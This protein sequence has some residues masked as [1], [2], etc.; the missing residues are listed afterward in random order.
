M[1]TS[2]QLDAIG[3][4]LDTGAADS[5]VRLLRSCWE[6]ELPPSELVRMYC[7]WIRGLCETGELDHAAT[8]AKRA[9]AEFPRSPDVLTA[10]GNVLDLTGDYPGAR[11]AFEAAL[12][13]EAASPLLHYN[14]G[15]ILERLGDDDAAERSY[16]DASAIEGDHGPMVEATSAL[17]ALLR[18]QGR[19]DEAEEVY[20]AY[21]DEDPLHI[22]ILV[23]HGICLSDLEHYEE[24]I[25][26]FDFALS[27]E[28]GHPSALYNKAITLYRLGLYDDALVTLD[29]ARV[30]DPENPLTLAVL[31]AWRLTAR[32]PDLDT[33]LGFLYRALDILEARYTGPLHVTYASI[34]AEEIFEALWQHS[35]RR[36]ARDVARLAARHEWITPHVLD[37]LNEADHGTSPDVST[38][39]VL[40]RAEARERPEH[41]PENSD[42][43]TTG[44]TV[45]ASDED[46]ARALTLEYL[47]AIEPSATVRFHVDVAPVEGDPTGH[48]REP[49]ARG[50]ARVTLYR[51]YNF[52]S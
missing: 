40:A 49:R 13:T 48:G 52:R 8:L 6:P 7:L 1:P 22:E 4:L 18:R 2:H 12:A 23:E 27:I 50:V 33:T 25:E 10:L 21:L 31:G 19:V 36:E 37:C 17:G 3:T 5:A 14:L 15:A 51:A 39:E 29:E 20:D 26:R 11:T 9:A 38:Y 42:G 34:V 30:V 32:D 44:L 28:P 16:R 35:R 43:Y 45:V 41:W 47:R 46:E 24:A